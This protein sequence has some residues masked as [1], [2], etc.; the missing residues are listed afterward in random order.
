MSSVTYGLV[1]GLI[2]FVVGLV[3]FLAFLPALGI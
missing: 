1:V 2:I 3:F